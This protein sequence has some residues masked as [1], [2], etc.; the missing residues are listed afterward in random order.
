MFRGSFAKLNLKTGPKNKGRVRW[1]ST[2]YTLDLL[3]YN[4]GLNSTAKKF[5]HTLVQHIK[6]SSNDA[7]G[8]RAL[9]MFNYNTILYIGIAII[10]LFKY[11]NHLLI[12]LNISSIFKKNKIKN[13]FIRGTNCSVILT[14][15]LL[16]HS[17]CIA[18]CYGLIFC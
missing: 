16:M 5:L 11:S 12:L 4:F 3:V 7:D 13:V 1:G 8:R 15:S 18:V 10:F 14:Q 2:Q 6:I 9:E 17:R